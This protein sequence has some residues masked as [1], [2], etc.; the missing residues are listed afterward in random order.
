M[1][2]PAVNPW[3]RLT[4]L[5]ENVLPPPPPPP[6]PVA[7]SENRSPL[8]LLTPRGEPRWTLRSIL[9]GGW[10]TRIGPGFFELSMGAGEPSCTSWLTAELPGCGKSPSATTADMNSARP[11]VAATVCSSFPGAPEWSARPNSWL[12]CSLRE[13]QGWI[14]RW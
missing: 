12:L 10:F 3:L 2:R 14:S 9:T 13:G 7:A 6:P 1:T 11:E 5:D 4:S 8:L